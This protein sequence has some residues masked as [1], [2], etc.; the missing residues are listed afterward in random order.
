MPLFEFP[1][2][3]Y[4][5]MLVLHFLNIH[6]ATYLIRFFL[7]H[8]YNFVQIHLAPKTMIQTNQQMHYAYLLHINYMFQFM[9]HP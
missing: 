8:I 1:L 6:K 4:I 2:R 9:I 5:H 7:F 3:I